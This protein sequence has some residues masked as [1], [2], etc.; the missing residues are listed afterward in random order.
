MAEPRKPQPEADV[1]V[2]LGSKLSPDG[3][4][5][6]SL[7]RRIAQAVRLFREGR[8]ENL[9]LSGGVHDHPMP[10]AEVMAG[11]A[12][13]AGIGAES[14]VIEARAVNTLENA[15]F[16]A[17]E[18]EKRGWRRAIVVS[19]NFHLPR[20]LRR[21]GHRQR[22]ARRLG[23]HV[24]EADRRRLGPRGGGAA[25]LRGPVPE[26]TGQTRCRAG[27]RPLKPEHG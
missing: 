22:C 8:A 3:R 15:A 11:M 7:K 19:D 21:R 20:A 5:T 10:E 9:L 17:E 27:T 13:D 24:G 1:I 25:R 23:R 4:P 2:V 18:M 14:I 6:P 12:R 26:R 16:T